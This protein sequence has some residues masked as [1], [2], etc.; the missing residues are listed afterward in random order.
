MFRWRGLVAA[1][2]LAMT[3]AGCS[4]QPNRKDVQLAIAPP[5]PSSPAKTISGPERIPAPT[6]VTA[7]APGEPVV[8]VNN[9]AGVLSGRIVWEGASDG[10]ALPER[11]RIDPK[12][13]GVADAVVFLAAPRAADDKPPPELSASLTQRDRVYVPR[14]Q[15]VPRGTVL[16]LRSADEKASFRASGAADFSCLAARGKEQKRT[17]K[18]PGLVEIRSE[19]N[20][21]LAGYIWVFAHPHFAVSDSQGRFS[22]A[23]VPPGSYEVELWH[24]GWRRDS[25]A[26]Q[27]K[28]RVEIGPGQGASIRWVLAERDAK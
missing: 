16:A 2:L 12:E 20:P 27:K 13:P 21:E 24:E 15:A 22:M 1:A 11:L 26:I 4:R 14:V 3:L 10:A 18:Q 6:L 7:L 28:V 5:S 17:L 8:I 23:Q 25:P 19:L 9:E